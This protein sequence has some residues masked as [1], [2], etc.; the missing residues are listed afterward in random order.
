M[1]NNFILKVLRLAQFD[2]NKKHRPGLPN[3]ADYF[4]RHTEKTVDLAAL[5]V[6][7][8]AERYI[9][10]IVENAVPNMLTVPQIAQATRSSET[11]PA[12]RL[13]SDDARMPRQTFSNTEN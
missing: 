1:I 3:I 11:L 4:S 2:Y 6:Q 8:T 12:L 5:S 9:N 7:Q 13:P 10:A